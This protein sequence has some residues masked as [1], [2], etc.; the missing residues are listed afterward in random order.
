MYIDTDAAL[1][2]IRIRCINSNIKK[3]IS[4]AHPQGNSSYLHVSPEKGTLV[5][6]IENRTLQFFFFLNL[7]DILN[8]CHANLFQN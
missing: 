8:I 1:R 7:L 6:D 3:G 4:V 2:Y 5:E